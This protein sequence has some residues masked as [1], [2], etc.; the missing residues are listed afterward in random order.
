MKQ[1][2]AQTDEQSSDGILRAFS[3]TPRQGATVKITGETCPEGIAFEA[4]PAVAAWRSGPRISGYEPEEVRQM[5]RAAGNPFDYDTIPSVK[6]TDFTIPGPAS[7]LPARLYDPAPSATGDRPS[8]I[9]FHGGGFCL[10]EIASYDGLLTQMAHDS[11]LLMVSVEYRLAPETPFPGGVLDTQQ[12][13]NWMYEHAADFGMDRARMAI[14]GDSAGGNLAA[15]ACVLNRD[16]GL[17]LP[18]VQWLI[19]PSTIANNSSDSRERLHDAPVIPK[20]ILAWMHNHY[21]QGGDSDDP[22]FN[23][24]ATPD[25]SGLPPAFILTAGYD[26]LM[27]EG[28]FYAN[29][30]RDAGVPV[31]YS[32]YTDMF[33]GFLNYGKLPQARAAV[34]ESAAVISAALSFC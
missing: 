4:R 27:D 12:A 29:R 2:D 31:R 8:L 28:E 22:R 20:E 16:A 33:H 24:M 26:P 18:A 3:E 30:L 32:C 23:V 21:M 10:G 15:V 6:K 19:Y 34:T 13:F 7:D 11:G 17:P 14:G 9:Y 1:S 25:L 5:R